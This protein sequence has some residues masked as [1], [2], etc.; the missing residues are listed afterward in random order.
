MEI[1]Q[2]V[3]RFRDLAPRIPKEPRRIGII[4]GQGQ[5]AP[6]EWLPQGCAYIRRE[7]GRVSGTKSFRYFIVPKEPGEFNLEKYFEWVFFNPAKKKYDTL[8]SQV[9]LRVHGESQRNQAIQST[10]LGSFY[11]RIELTDNTL[12]TT[13]PGWLKT[14]VNIFVLLIL[15]LS[16]WLVFKKPS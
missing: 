14:G 12:R 6:G 11:D 10:D 8:R 13:G 7:S 5:F 4:A 1:H 3:S 2:P 16:V 9:T 15:G